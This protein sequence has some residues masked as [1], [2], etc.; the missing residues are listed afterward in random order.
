M[1]TPRKQTAPKPPADPFERAR[2]LCLALPEATERPSHGEP[3]FFVK[4]KLFVTFSIDHHHDGEAAIWIKAAPGVQEMLIDENPER[5]Y[6]PPYVG[7]SG[8]V[9]ARMDRKGIP[10]DDIEALI[11]CLDARRAEAAR[12][13]PCRHA[14]RA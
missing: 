10:W 5:Y 2:A 12:C 9:A 7:V 14:R 11:R 4:G 13:E 6:R 8:W 1:A 3:A